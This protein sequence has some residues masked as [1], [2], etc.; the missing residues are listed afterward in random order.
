MRA[1]RV[2]RDHRF[3]VLREVADLPDRCTTPAAGSPSPASTRVR[4]VLP[5]PLRPTRPTFVAGAT[6]KLASLEQQTRPGAQLD[7]R[8]HVIIRVTYR[9]TRVVGPRRILRVSM[10]QRAGSDVEAQ[11]AQHSRPSSVIL[12]GPHGG[13]HTQLMRKPST[14]RPAPPGSDPRSH[15]SAGRQPTSASCRRLLCCRRRRDA[16]D[17][18]EVDHVDA[19]F[20]VDD[21][22]HRLGHDR[23]R[24]LSTLLHSC[25]A[26][27]VRMSLV[28]WSRASRTVGIR[29]PATAHP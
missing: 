14:N 20:G 8:Q 16:V 27:L 12:S 13:I 18:A 19:E 17:Q 21:V 28:S 23:R 11:G 24:W 15:R 4:V 22:V 3:G 7:A 25:P 6:R 9:V 10:P 1:G 29:Q 5:A 26:P 2:G